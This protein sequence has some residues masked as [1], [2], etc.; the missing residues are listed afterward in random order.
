MTEL[1]IPK[2]SLNTLKMV[3]RAYKLSYNPEGLSLK[4]ISTNTGFPKS[5]I[6]RSN[7]FLIDTGFL[8]KVGYKFRLSDQGKEY[9]DYL[10][11]KKDE[12][13]REQL[14]KILLSYEPINLVIKFVQL[15]REVTLKQLE[16]RIINLAEA[17]MERGE[18]KEGIKCLIDMLSES[19]IL[20]E[21]NNIYSLDHNLE[22]L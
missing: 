18:H 7:S 3:I 2:S 13:S 20:I 22:N 1:K 5:Q 19:L 14:K 11:N 16:E 9:A 17:D 12:Q 6:Q 4:E 8:E 15:Y 21:T 10:E